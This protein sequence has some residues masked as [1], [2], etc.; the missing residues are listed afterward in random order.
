LPDRA[1]GDPDSVEAGL[2]VVGP[3][4]GAIGASDAVACAPEKGCAAAGGGGVGSAVWAC[5]G[6]SPGYTPEVLAST[7]EPCMALSQSE[8]I[9]SAVRRAYKPHHSFYSTIRPDLFNGLLNPSE[10]IVVGRHVWTLRFVVVV[11]FSNGGALLNISSSPGI[12]V[13]L[14]DVDWFVLEVVGNATKLLCIAQKPVLSP[15]P[16]LS[17]AITVG[18]RIR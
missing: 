16:S 12:W 7:G 18:G 3:D 6:F 11:I 14:S 17:N 10:R 13:E 4:E 15:W 8:V 5:S 2:A 9:P 1:A